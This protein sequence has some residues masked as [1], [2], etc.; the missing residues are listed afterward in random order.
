MSIEQHTPGP[1]IIDGNEAFVDIVSSTGDLIAE[2][3][4]DNEHEFGNARLIAAAPELLETLKKALEASNCDGDLCAY[5]WHEDARRVIAK[6]TE[7]P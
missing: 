7:A 3:E 5:A 1:W 2:V 6:S 4:P